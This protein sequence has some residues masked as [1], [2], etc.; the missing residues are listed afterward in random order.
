MPFIFISYS[1]KDTEYANRLAD[2][3]EARGI[4]VWIDERIDFGARWPQAIEE[5]LDRC[6]AFVVVMTPDSKKSEWVQNELARALRLRMPIYPLLLEGDVWLALEA[7]Q[8][9]DVRGNT[10]PPERFY[11]GLA[12][13][14]AAADAQGSS[15][16]SRRERLQTELG[17]MQRRYDNLTRRI[18]A[19]DTDLGREMDG[20]RRLILEERRTELAGKREQTSTSMTQIERELAEQEAS[21][22]GTTVSSDAVRT[23]SGERLPVL[24]Q[25]A[26]LGQ[27]ELMPLDVRDMVRRELAN[28]QKFGYLLSKSQLDLLASHREALSLD[29]D[30]LVMV[31]RSAL[32]LSL[33]HI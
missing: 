28:F 29:D 3:L 19:V 22:P 10:L 27:K 14:L 6:A 13:I 17:E 23:I 33:I 8:Y 26:L 1:H 18:A 11:T 2:S 31:L 15:F 16:A 12:R 24:Q 4:H 7:T 20:E 32:A 25:P 21:K 30:E 9:V 5:N